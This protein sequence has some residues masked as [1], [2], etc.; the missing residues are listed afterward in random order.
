MTTPRV[1]DA[2]VRGIIDTTLSDLTPFINTAHLVVDGNLLNEGY[3]DDILTSIELWLSAHYVAVQDPRVKS[4]ALG[5]GSQTNYGNA[6]M[7]FNFTPYG[8]QVLALD[9]SGIL[10]AL[11]RRKAKMWNV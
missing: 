6:A 10:A 2:D 8:Q 9:S 5:D 7:G 11:G 1:T 3:S 4:E